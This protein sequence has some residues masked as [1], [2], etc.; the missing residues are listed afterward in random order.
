MRAWLRYVIW[1]SLVVVAFAAG[2]FLVHSPQALGEP[3]GLASVDAMTSTAK[4]F[5]LADAALWVVDGGPLGL[6]RSDALR[7]LAGQTKGLGKTRLCRSVIAISELDD[8]VTT[9]EGTEVVPLIPE[10]PSSDAAMQ[11]LRARVLSRADLVDQLVS[12]DGQ[13]ALVICLLQ[14]PLDE[15]TWVPANPR[16]TQWTRV[17]ARATAA[18]LGGD[19]QLSAVLMA[20][21]SLP[22]MLLLQ[23]YEKRYMRRLSVWGSLTLGVMVILS[24]VVTWRS[25]L[26]ARDGFATVLGGRAFYAARQLDLVTKTSATALVTVTG[27]FTSSSGLRSLEQTCAELGAHGSVACPTDALRRAASA[28]TG[29]AVLPA[30]D[31]QAKQLWF[32]L[33]ERPEL[34]LLFTQDRQHALVRLRGKFAAVPG[35]TTLPASL[36]SLY[37]VSRSLRSLVASGLLLAVVGC[38]A[39]AWLGRRLRWG[40]FPLATALAVT[41]F[42]CPVAMLSLALLTLSVWTVFASLAATSITMKD[43]E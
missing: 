6:F 22:L 39:A 34:S 18:M 13:R 42:A 20:A 1:L 19:L 21:L 28:L 9:D 26:M 37:A 2:R 43:L 17:D 33:G 4:Q 8:P 3:T 25:M 36:A 40:S 30:T 12:G 24:S 32:L 16:F 41:A 35:V 10:I 27:D 38:V 29:D 7:E 11:R 5:A 31:E 15:M 14:R 23:M